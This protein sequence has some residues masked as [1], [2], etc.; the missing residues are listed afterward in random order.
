MRCGNYKC[1]AALCRGC[2][3]FRGASCAASPACRMSRWYA[4]CRACYTRAR[5]N[6][7]P[8]RRLGGQA[9]VATRRSCSPLGASR[10]AS[11]PGVGASGVRAR[12]RDG[13]HIGPRGLRLHSSPLPLS[14]R[15][16]CGCTWVTQVPTCAR[17]HIISTRIPLFL[18]LSRVRGAACTLMHPHMRSL[19]DDRRPQGACKPRAAGGADSRERG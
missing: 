6:A 7:L 19:T 17:R 2:R 15:T 3:G 14:A 10:Y 18:C 12:R 9:Q 4:S 8:R 13:L 11:A 16:R 5:P 1:C